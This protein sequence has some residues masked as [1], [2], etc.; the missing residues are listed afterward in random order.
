MA[1]CPLLPSRSTTN[2]VTDG[3]TTV[4]S[5]QTDNTGPERRTATRVSRNSSAST[6]RDTRA[7]DAKPAIPAAVSGQRLDARARATRAARP[8]ATV[9]LRAR[10]AQLRKLSHSQSALRLGTDTTRLG[11]RTAFY[12]SPCRLRLDVAGQKSQLSQRRHDPRRQHPPRVDCSRLPAAVTGRPAWHGQSQSAALATPR[13]LRAR[14]RTFFPY[15]AAAATLQSA[16]ASDR[17][18]LEHMHAARRRRPSTTSRAAA[19]IPDDA[20]LITNVSLSDYQSVSTTSPHAVSIILVAPSAA[21][22]T[23]SPAPSRLP[24]GREASPTLWL[25]RL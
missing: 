9:A 14:A 5:W 17:R 13:S 15:K 3:C 8:C 11:A 2:T 19:Q 6:T 24:C 4:R 12:D 21:A 23:G 7:Y 10:R 16:Y 25:Q 20:I 22:I 1:P 18:G